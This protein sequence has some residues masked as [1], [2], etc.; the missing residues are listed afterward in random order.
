MRIVIVG[1]SKRFEIVGKLLKNEKGLDDLPYII[2]QTT[3]HDEHPDLLQN[4]ISGAEQFEIAIVMSENDSNDLDLITKIAASVPVT[5][6]FV[7]APDIDFC[8][9]AL[10]QGAWDYQEMVQEPRGDWYKRLCDSIGAGCQA[11]RLIVADGRTDWVRRYISELV[12]TYPGEWIAVRDTAEGVLKHAHGYN[13]LMAEI[14]D[15]EDVLI[16]RLP[17]RYPWST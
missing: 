7:P 10:R 8:I 4:V 11:R 12:Q 14:E 5:I 6:V 1:Q 3:D 13:S 16:W 15:R 2:S 17:E 9:H